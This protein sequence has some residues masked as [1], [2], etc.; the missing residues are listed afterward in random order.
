MVTADKLGYY[1]LKWIHDD[2]RIV[3]FEFD[4]PVTQVVTIGVVANLMS[5]SNQYFIVKGI[6][7]N[8]V[9]Q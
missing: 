5:S 3:T 1:D 2:Y 9:N 7:I 8:Q 6:S 4:N